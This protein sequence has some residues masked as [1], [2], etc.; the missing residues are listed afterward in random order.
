MLNLRRIGVT[1][2]FLLTAVGCADEADRGATRER[3]FQFGQPSLAGI[4]DQTQPEASA[5]YEHA[6]RFVSEAG[7]DAASFDLMNP[8]VSHWCPP[9][10]VYHDWLV[11]FP[12]VVGRS[13][14]GNALAIAVLNDGKCWVWQPDA[15][16]ASTE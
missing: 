15:A 14:V 6:K 10:A 9:Q 1:S 13:E 11:S 3:V 4:S 5:A 12:G 2:I 7:V 16:M 8:S